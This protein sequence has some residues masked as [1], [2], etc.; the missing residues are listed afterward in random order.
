MEE[1]NKA[2]IIAAMTS[3]NDLMAQNKTYLTEL[4]SAIGDGD[5]GLTM[6]KGFKAALESAS[7]YTG[8]D[9]GAMLKMV[10]FSMAKSVPS[11]MGT[12]MATAFLGAGKVMD[13]IERI[14]VEKFKIVFR[15]M[16]DAVSAR[17]RSNEG[18]KTL[19][20]VL[21]PV[22]RAAE[23]YMGEDPAE[24]LEAVLKA[25][26]LGLEKTKEMINQHGKAAVFREKSLGLLDPG[27]MAAYL[28]IKGFATAKNN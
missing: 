17:G 3:I 13:G 22:A 24:L 21:Y 10:G 6:T 4:D 11:T 16:A 18:E 12:L 19:L 28:M 8:N 23:S 2:Y 25:A 5:L 7:S 26:E 15:S 1:Y 20:D 9:I 27:A 14:D